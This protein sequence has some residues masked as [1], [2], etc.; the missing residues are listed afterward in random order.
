MLINYCYAYDRMKKRSRGEKVTDP[1]EQYR[2]LK[3]VE[4]IVEERFRKG[5]IPESD[6]RRFIGKLRRWEE[7]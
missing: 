2:K 1:E 3:K 5:I 7:D 6:Y 4:P